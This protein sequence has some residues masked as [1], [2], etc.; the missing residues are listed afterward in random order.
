MMVGSEG[1]RS[2]VKTVK[3]LFMRSSVQASDLRQIKCFIETHDSLPTVTIRRIHL[4]FNKNDLHKRGN[5]LY[6]N[7]ESQLIFKYESL[8]L[9][10]IYFTTAF[11]FYIYIY[12][13]HS[14]D[15][16]RTYLLHK[17]LLFG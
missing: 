17:L 1:P 14:H 2:L 7:L 16:R 6:R 4:S 11:E 5:L 15:H 13:S 3:E 10:P 8:V 12:Y 9:F